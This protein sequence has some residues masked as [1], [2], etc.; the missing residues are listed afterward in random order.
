MVQWGL[1]NYG[2][3]MKYIKVKGD[4]H[5][6]VEAMV[7]NYLLELHE[8]PIPMKDLIP[9]MEHILG[10]SRCHAEY[11]DTGEKEL[12]AWVEKNQETLSDWL[13]TTSQVDA[14]N[15]ERILDAPECDWDELQAIE[16][17]SLKSG[18]M[19]RSELSKRNIGCSSPD[20]DKYETMWV[21]LE[22]VTLNILK[23]AKALGSLSK[24]ELC[25]A[26]AISNESP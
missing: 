2:E 7:P 11:V 1:V 19:G 25:L 18:S 4:Y 8:N 17:F 21:T 15:W 6:N 26:L 13:I 12:N 20:G 16:L 24:D 10:W 9:L 5:H 14:E 22:D 23:S 3:N